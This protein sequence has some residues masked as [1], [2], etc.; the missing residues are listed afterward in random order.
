MKK[1]IIIDWAYNRL[2]PKMEFESFEDGWD[3]IYENIEDEDNAYEDI[4]VILEEDYSLKVK[5]LNKSLQRTKGIDPSLTIP[6][7]ISW[8]VGSPRQ[9]YEGIMKLL[10]KFWQMY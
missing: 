5:Q 10:L 8:L 4:F 9:L 7:R 6:E 1:W 3:F 2:F